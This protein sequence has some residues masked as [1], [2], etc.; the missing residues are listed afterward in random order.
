MNC[1]QDEIDYHLEIA[2]EVESTHIS[3]TRI[4]GAVIY[5]TATFCGIIITILMVWII[6][7][8]LLF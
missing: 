7:N 8:Y 2:D 3:F 4:I 6:W 5:C 1:K